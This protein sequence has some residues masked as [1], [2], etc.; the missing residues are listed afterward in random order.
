MIR[1]LLGISLIAGLLL[2]ACNESTIVGSEILGDDFVDVGYTDTF[3]L[4]SSIIPGDSARVYPTSNSLFLLG[5]IDD[6]VFGKSSTEVYTQIRKIYDIPD[7]DNAILDSVVLSIGINNDGFWGD[8][9]AEHT[10]EVFELNESLIEYDSIY[11]NQ[12]F[13]KGMLLGTKSFNP[14]FTDTSTV[15]F[16]EDTS[17]YVN[18]F[19]MPLEKS[20]GEKLLA[21]TLALQND[22]LIQEL[23]NGLVIRSTTGTSSVFGMSTSVV[24][25]DYT[26]KLVLYFTNNGS[27]PEQYVLTL[28]GKRGTYIETDRSGTVLQQFMDDP[29]G[30]DSLL[31]ISGLLNNYID[32]EIPYFE[33]LNKDEV[34]INYAELELTLNTED[35][36]AA[37]EP[38]ERIYAYNVDEEG[39]RSYVYDLLIA[40]QDGSIAYFDGELVEE[41]TENGNTIAKYNINLTNELKRRID[42]GDTGTKIRLIPYLS[43]QRANRSVLYGT[44]SSA[45]PAKL[46]VTFTQQ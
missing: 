31:F 15:I 20:F 30:G 22:T 39:T 1:Y 16:Q 4:K 21:D 25:D 13:E 12:Q 32:L 3:T 34:M 10:V 44:G 11:T 14:Y 38:V 29:Q 18:I 42:E 9:L 37:Y 24:L 6:P 26:N 28:G 2:S 17:S 43:T 27:E 19:R 5:N 23:T 33:D 46:K 36:N 45:H 41:E 40:L 8:S 35:V 7:I